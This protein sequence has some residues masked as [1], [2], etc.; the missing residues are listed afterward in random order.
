[1]NIIII[2]LFIFAY[3]SDSLYA[4]TMKKAKGYKKVVQTV[5]QNPFMKTDIPA[6]MAAPGPPLG[7]MLGQVCAL[8][9]SFVCKKLQTFSGLL[10]CVGVSLLDGDTF[11]CHWYSSHTSLVGLADS[12]VIY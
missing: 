3:L 5:I 11:A 9:F 1:M 2:L 10:I 8:K 4:V 6:G 12:L 7:P